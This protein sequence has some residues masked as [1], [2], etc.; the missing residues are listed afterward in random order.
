MNLE[1][2][3]LLGLT[4]GGVILPFIDDLRTD[5]NTQIHVAAIAFFLIIFPAYFAFAASNTESFT[6]SGGPVGDYSVTGTYSYHQIG[7]GS[8][9]VNDGDTVNVMANSD[10]AGDGIDGKNIVGVRATLT[11]TD[12]ETQQGAGC[13]LP[14]ADDSVDDDVSGTMMHYGLEETSPT[15]SGESVTLEWHNSSIIGTTVTNMSE[16]DI[17]MMLDGMGIGLGEHSLDISVSVNTG[18]GPGCQTTDDGEE[19]AYT[20][21]LIS[22]EYDI[23]MVEVEPEEPEE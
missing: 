22:L 19:V 10:A 16:S 23:E 5:R 2:N 21:E 18:G 4:T 14:T 17:M 12:D 9:Y 7:D 20:I 13:N 1:Y 11:F 6:I 15:L 3:I 8:Q